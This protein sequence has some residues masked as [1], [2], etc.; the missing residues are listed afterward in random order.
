MVTYNVVNE[1]FKEH[2]C[3]LLMT[4]EEFNKKPR[5]VNEKYPYIASCGDKNEV[6]FHHFKYTSQGLKCPKC[7]HLESSINKIEKYKLNPVSRI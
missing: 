2:G 5:T 6:Y 1:K 4:E 3:E 7:V